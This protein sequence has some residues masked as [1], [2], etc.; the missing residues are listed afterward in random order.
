M[1]T[2][3]LEVLGKNYITEGWSGGATHL[4]FHSRETIPPKLR[5]LVQSFDN[6]SSWVDTD[7]AL[8]F[9]VEVGDKEKWD[10]IFPGNATVRR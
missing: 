3:E 7:R 4:V 9:G 2:F 8:G 10:V 5:S 1:H 6:S